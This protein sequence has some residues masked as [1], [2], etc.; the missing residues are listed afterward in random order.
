MIL[1]ESNNDFENKIFASLF[2]QKK[3]SVTLNSSSNFFFKLNFLIQSD[4]LKITHAEKRFI[5]KLPTSFDQVFVTV[6]DYLS[7]L[8]L[9]YF[10]FQY[11]PILQ[12]ISYLNKTINL[13][14]IHNSIIKHLI[15]NMENGFDKN[16]L[17]QIIWP[18]DKEI[19]LNKLDTH[20]TNLKNKFKEIGLNIKFSSNNGQLKLIIN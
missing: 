20:M 9:N 18:N 17:Y 2:E 14:S 4:L 12:S 8:N 7:N 11:N 15:L 1:F 3:I 5:F 10:S 19:Q 16:F 6:Y 13:G